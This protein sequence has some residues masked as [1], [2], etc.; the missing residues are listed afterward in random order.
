MPTVDLTPLPPGAAG[1]LLTLQRAAYVTEAQLYDD[2][3]LPALVQTLAELE[4]ELTTGSC[5]AARAGSRLVGAVRTRE[6][7]GVLHVGRLVVAPDLQGHGIG[8]RL[9]LAA[10]QATGLPRATLFTGARSTA[11][12]RLYGR[13]G[14]VESHR[15]RVRPGLELVHLVKE[16]RPTEGG[17]GG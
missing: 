14:Y 12:L 15:E 11:N 5:L 3:R 7:D 10:E 17:S 2:V 6:R 4:H 8:T 16:L 13:H 9:L 1:E